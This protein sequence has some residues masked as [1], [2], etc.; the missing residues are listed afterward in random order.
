MMIPEQPWMCETMNCATVSTINHLKIIVARRMPFRRR[1]KWGQC[2]AGTTCFEYY[3]KIWYR[4]SL[5]L[6]LAVTLPLFRGRFR[7]ESCSP[8]RSKHRFWTASSIE[9]YL[10]VSRVLKLHINIYDWDETL[11]V[12]IPPPNPSREIFDHDNSYHLS[13]FGSNFPE[14]MLDMAIIAQNMDYPSRST[15][16]KCRKKRRAIAWPQTSIFVQLLNAVCR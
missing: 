12:S 5:V 6:L 11:S 13:L 9:F 1:T 8:T 16:P 14:Q 2:D 4:N 3:H 15:R 10:I 7:D